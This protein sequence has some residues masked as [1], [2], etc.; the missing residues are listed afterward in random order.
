ML[1][2]LTYE[3][4]YNLGNYENERIGAEVALLGPDDDVEAAYALAVD[5][6]NAEK[7]RRDIARGWIK[8]DPPKP[9]DD[10]E[11]PF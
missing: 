2:K 6:V 3:R 1:T 10:A 5:A 4:L 9:A 8:P 7:R 11:I